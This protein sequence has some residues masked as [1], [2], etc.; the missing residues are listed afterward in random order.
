[1]ASP[2][3]KQPAFFRPRSATPI[4]SILRRA[5]GAYLHSKRYHLAVAQTGSTRHDI[6]G[7]PV[8]PVSDDDRLAAE[9]KIESLKKRDD[10]RKAPSA[11]PAVA[12]SISLSRADTI[13]ASLL[14]R[15][16]PPR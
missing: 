7:L 4:S 6:N 1:M 13:R 3:G 16:N 2:I 8:E 14:N 5:T 15:N 10:A 12:R 9:E 11:A